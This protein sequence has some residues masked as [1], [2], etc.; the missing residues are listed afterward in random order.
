MQR[1]GRLWLACGKYQ[2]LEEEIEKI[3]AVSVKAIK[4]LID[5]Y[6]L[7]QCT[8]GKMIPAPSK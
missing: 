2:T 5:Q 6:P 8:L 1:L 4:D 3:N 7:D